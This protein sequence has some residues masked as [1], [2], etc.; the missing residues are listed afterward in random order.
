MLDDYKGPSNS[1]ALWQYLV[2]E[3]VTGAFWEGGK[4]VLIFSSGDAIAFGQSPSFWVMPP[5]EWQALVIQR[6]DAITR[7]CHELQ[8]LAWLPSLA[9]AERSPKTGSAT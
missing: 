7:M 6:R 8:N 9:K 1:N 5:H 4:I 3:V 2:G